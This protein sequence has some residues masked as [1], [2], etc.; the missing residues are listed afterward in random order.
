LFFLSSRRRKVTVSF[1]RDDDPSEYLER[2]NAELPL[3]AAAG[4]DCLRVTRDIGE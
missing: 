1:L 3:L 2:N 4:F